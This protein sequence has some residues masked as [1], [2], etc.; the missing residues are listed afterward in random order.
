[1]I[2]LHLLALCVFYIT[3]KMG[4]SLTVRLKNIA[5]KFIANFFFQKSLPVYTACRKS[6]RLLVL[7]HPLRELNIFS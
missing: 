7:S 6:R 3:T 5:V 1:M 4:S 2:I